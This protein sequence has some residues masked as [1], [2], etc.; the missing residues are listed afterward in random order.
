MKEALLADISP[1]LV[2]I[3][4]V[5]ANAFLV[6]LPASAEAKG[7]DFAYARNPPETK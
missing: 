4:G 2:G 7:F 1:K 6:I 3:A 5:G